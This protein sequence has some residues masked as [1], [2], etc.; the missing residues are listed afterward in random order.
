MKVITKNLMYFAILFIMGAI[1]FR[2]GLSHFLENHSYNLVWI[3]AAIY[4][5]F[6]FF[7]GWFFGKR[8][9]ETLPLY[10]VGLRFHTVTYLLFN[11]VSGLWFSIGFHSHFESIRIVYVTA[12]FWGIGLL[13][14]FIIYLKTRKN[15]I[16]GIKKSEIFE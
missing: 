6:N 8:D 1:V 3:L 15:A 2:Y 14:H 13:I 4:F 10:D 12:F 9:Y 7:I 16:K 5:L 11:I